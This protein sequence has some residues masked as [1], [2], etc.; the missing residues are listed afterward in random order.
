MK[1]RYPSLIIFSVINLII[2]LAVGA[3][4]IYSMFNPHQPIIGKIGSITT[5]AAIALCL[6]YCFYG[7]NKHRIA[8]YRAFLIVYLIALLFNIVTAISLDG[9]LLAKICT[10]IFLVIVYGFAVVFVIHP[11]L[12]NVQ[13]YTIT[14]VMFLC[15]IGACL[16]LGLIGDITA[17]LD[18]S[19]ST[20]LRGVGNIVLTICVCVTTVAQY[21]LRY[22]KEK[23]DN[24]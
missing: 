9:N 21:R 11:E 1:E 18:A 22:I 10:V 19:S 24:R 4:T 8:T 20:I 14:T 13:L 17:P 23:I 5:L 6:L 7:Y 16:S 2:L 15:V 3:Y 12:S